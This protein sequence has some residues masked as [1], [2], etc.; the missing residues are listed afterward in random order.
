[1]MRIENPGKTQTAN[2]R[3]DLSITRRVMS[4]DRNRRDSKRLQYV[5]HADGSNYNRRR[6]YGSPNRRD[7]KGRDKSV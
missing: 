6:A 5:K 7:R 3:A 2:R 1:M 4:T